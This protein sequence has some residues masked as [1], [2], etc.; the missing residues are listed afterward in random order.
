MVNFNDFVDISTKKSL[1]LLFLNDFI[2]LLNFQQL[3]RDT[4]LYL[5]SSELSWE[6]RNDQ[7]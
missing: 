2:I 4:A 5:I 7:V 3:F 6:T 1:K